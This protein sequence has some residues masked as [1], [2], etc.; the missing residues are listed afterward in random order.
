MSA[1]TAALRAGAVIGGRPIDETAPAPEDYAQW[2][3]GGVILKP[4]PK[5]ADLAVTR[6]ARYASPIHGAAPATAA[7][8]AW[9]AAQDRWAPVI[10][11]ADADAAAAAAALDA[12]AGWVP[13]PAAGLPVNHYVIDFESDLFVGKL[14]IY[15]KG[16]PSSYEPYFAGKKRRS[17]MMLQGRFKRPLLLDDVVTGQEFGR[18]YKNLRGCWLMEK[19]RI[20]VFAFLGKQ[21]K[22]QRIPAAASATRDYSA[23]SPRPRADPPNPSPPTHQTHA[24]HP[25]TTNRSCSRL[26]SA[27]CPRWSSAT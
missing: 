9:E 22:R 25:T 5:S 4:S 21:G 24:A 13:K 11:E 3:D 1:A 19:V 2:P 6:V 18:P 10:A 16:L 26:P 27:S 14:L 23:T 7:H 17:V 12:A 15:I 20:T 8:R